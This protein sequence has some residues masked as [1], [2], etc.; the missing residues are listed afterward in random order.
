MQPMAILV[1][2][3]FLVTRFGVLQTLLIA[4]IRVL[5]TIGLY[6]LK[7][8]VWLPR[9]LWRIGI[10]NSFFL[11]FFTFFGVSTEV[12]LLQ[13]QR[14]AVQRVHYFTVYIME[15]KNNNINKQWKK[16][17]SKTFN[18]CHRQ[19]SKKYYNFFKPAI[20]NSHR[21]LTGH[22]SILIGSPRN[23]WKPLTNWLTV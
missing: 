14:A 19:T 6:M 10:N 2:L 22:E 3:L 1:Q 13:L 9:L 21:V 15:D 7:P 12:Q 8:R 18:L 17:L 5:F 11:A 20:S 4:N 16:R 23:N